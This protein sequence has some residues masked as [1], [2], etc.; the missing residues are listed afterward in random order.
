MTEQ[1]KQPGPAFRLDE[2]RWAA[3][4]ARDPAAHSAFVYAVLT[5]GVYCRPTCPSR[6][7]RK[8]NA[9]FY[10]APEQAAKAGFRPCKRCRPERQTPPPGAD[11]RIVRACRILEQAEERIS[12]DGLAGMV[13]LSAFHFQ[14]LFKK[15]L[16][17]SP[18][19][20]AAGLSRNRLQQGLGQGLSVTEAGLPG[21][22]RLRLPGL[23]KIRRVA[24]HETHRV[25]PRRRHERDPLRPGEVRPGALFWWRPRP[26]GSA[27][28]TWVKAARSWWSGSRRASPGPG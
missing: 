1:G 19:E 17:L 14:R 10:D 7:P 21:R 4:L 8:E 22:V 18:R 27:A 28:S 11:P 3:V 5:T 26:G 13:D 2:A 9:L 6:K 12:L 20:Y 16:G 15:T 24:G 23:R 25:R